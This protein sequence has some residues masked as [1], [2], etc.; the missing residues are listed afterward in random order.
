MLKRDAL[1]HY[2]IKKH[3]WGEAHM[4]DCWVLGPNCLP[5]TFIYKASANY[6][7]E[8][9]QKNNTKCKFYVVRYD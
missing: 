6:M 4:S 3:I 9:L 2:G 1:Y 8:Q 7:C 5:L